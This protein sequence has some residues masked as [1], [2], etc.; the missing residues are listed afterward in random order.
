VNIQLNIVAGPM[1]PGKFMRNDVVALFVL[2][3]TVTVTLPISV[4]YKV[5]VQLCEEVAGLFSVS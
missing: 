5:Q 2:L 4:R 3:S 1:C